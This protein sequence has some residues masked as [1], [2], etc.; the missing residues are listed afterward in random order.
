M[1]D[2][3][4]PFD[5]VAMTREIIGF[6]SMRTR[7]YDDRSGLDLIPSRRLEGHPTIGIGRALDTCGITVAEAHYLW[8][9]DLARYREEL[10]RL[11]WFSGLDP[12]RQ[13]AIISMRHQLGMAGLLEFHGMISA[14]ERQH[15]TAASAAMLASI[16]AGQTPQRATLLAHVMQTGTP[17]KTVPDDH[18]GWNIVA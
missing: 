5:V 1:S 10:A 14:I 6:E 13:R 8:C 4:D 11:S 18:G 2:K 15:W 12:V 7:V 3:L 16:W 9:N 17:L